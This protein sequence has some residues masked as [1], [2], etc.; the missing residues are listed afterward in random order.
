VWA[1]LLRPGITQRDIGDTKEQ[2]CVVIVR[3]KSSLALEFERALWIGSSPRIRGGIAKQFVS[4][5]YFGVELNG[6]A[7]FGDG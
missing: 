7:K 3:D 6:F 1:G 5:G 2:E 4:A